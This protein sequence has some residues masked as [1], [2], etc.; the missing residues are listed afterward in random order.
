MHV[1]ILGCGYLGRRAADLWRGAG[2][3]VSILTRSAARAAALRQAGWQ[4]YV[5]DVLD[6]DS[7]AALPDADVLLYAVGYD[8]GA[9]VDKRQVYVEGLRHALET[10]GRRAGRILYV[11]SSSVYGQAAGEWID[12]TSPTV[13]GT[14]GG[15][16]CLAAEQVLREFSNGFAGPCCVLRLTGIYGPGR[17][18]AKTETLRQ[19]LPLSGSPDAWLNLIHVADAARICVTAAGHPQPEPLY[20]VTDDRPVQ[21]GE[22]YAELARLLD[23]PPPRFDPA[24]TPRHGQG[25]NKRCRNALLKASLGIALTYPTIQEGLPAS[26]QVE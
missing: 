11:S 7:L 16:I 23:A 1:L 14:E 21:R 19:G 9:G 13:P 22:Y 15:E 5:G 2:H 10:V 26:L 6:A 17:L 4:P 12:E 18:L 3:A 25:L 20:L 24:E 8:R